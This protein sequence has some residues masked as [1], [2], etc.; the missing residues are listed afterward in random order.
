MLQILTVVKIHTANGTEMHNH[1]SKQLHSILAEDGCTFLTKY[2]TF[3]RH[4]TDTLLEWSD[5][6][7]VTVIA[8]LL[9]D[10]IHL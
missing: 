7:D 2:V 5:V 10:L 1:H 9:I 3:C 4:D 8:S 6:S